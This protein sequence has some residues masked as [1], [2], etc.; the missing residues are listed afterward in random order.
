MSAKT[1]IQGLEDSQ[2]IKIFLD[3]VASH[4][5]NYEKNK[6]EISYK[7]YEATWVLPVAKATG[8]GRTETEAYKNALKNLLELLM[9]DPTYIEYFSVILSHLS[10]A[11][12]KDPSPPPKLQLKTEGH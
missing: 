6:K 12:N 1:I 3:F 8:Y 10:L 11:K 7:C 5:L 9:E 2:L 4:R